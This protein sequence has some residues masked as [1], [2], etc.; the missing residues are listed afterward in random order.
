[1]P[2]KSLPGSLA[3]IVLVITVEI[4]VNK[5]SISISGINLNYYNL[6]AVLITVTLILAF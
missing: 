6:M 5:I 4:I 3:D 2:V 1:M